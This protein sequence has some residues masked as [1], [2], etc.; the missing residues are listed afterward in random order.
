MRFGGISWI[1]STIS[2]LQSRCVVWMV[3]PW[4][5]TTTAKLTDLPMDLNSL[6]DLLDELNLSQP[7][8]DSAVRDD[9]ELNKERFH[10]TPISRHLAGSPAPLRVAR[11]PVTFLVATLRWPPAAALTDWPFCGAQHL[12]K[13]ATLV[14]SRWSFAR[15]HMFGRMV[16]CGECHCGGISDRGLFSSVVLSQ[17]LARSRGQQHLSRKT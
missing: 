10:H 3:G 15:K 1:T 17:V 7:F 13:T 4:C 6:L 12:G 14:P 2:N 11:S 5:C 16:D 9:V 8:S